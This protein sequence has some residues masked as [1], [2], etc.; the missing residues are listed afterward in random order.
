M[1]Q[2]TFKAIH[3][4]TIDR[5]TP[6]YYGKDLFRD[7]A[8]ILG[9][10]KS[11][12]RN[13]IH[14]FDLLAPDDGLPLEATSQISLAELLA[15]VTAVIGS[16]YNMLAE[17]LTRTDYDYLTATWAEY[18]SGRVEATSLK[19]SLWTIVYGDANDASL[20]TWAR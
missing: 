4:V 14:T 13:V 5:I 12:D 17:R 19:P 6:S 18:K 20:N 15:N 2:S 3:T 16:P 8:L 10:S 11:S 9:A 1:A 7:G